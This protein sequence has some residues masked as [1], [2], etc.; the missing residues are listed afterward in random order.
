MK[1]ELLKAVSN[2]EDRYPG[3]REALVQAALD[4]VTD[5]AEHDDRRLNINQRFDAQI[6]R[7][8]QQ[9]IATKEGGVA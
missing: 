6:E 4:C 2:L 8:A 9:A 3:Y 5:T 7:I 1:V